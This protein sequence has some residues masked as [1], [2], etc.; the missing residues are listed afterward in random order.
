MHLMLIRHSTMAQPRA[1]PVEDM[2]A[3]VDVAATEYSTNDKK[4]PRV[5]PNMSFCPIHVWACPYVYTFLPLRPLV[6]L[7]GD[8]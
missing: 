2:E 1:A 4:H 8:P 3:I 7:V 6:E 5:G